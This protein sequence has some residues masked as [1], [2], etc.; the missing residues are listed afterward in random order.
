M[1]AFQLVTLVELLSLRMARQF[2]RSIVVERSPSLLVP[3]E[4][5]RFLCIVGRAIISS[6]QTRTNNP[7][8]TCVC[9]PGVAWFRVGFGAQIDFV[10][11]LAVGWCQIWRG[12]V[13]T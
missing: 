6:L 7:V 1:L 12:V 2:L 10:F 3:R 5:P 13:G 8:V 9:Q 11:V 4:Q